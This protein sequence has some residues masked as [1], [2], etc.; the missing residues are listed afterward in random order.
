MYGYPGSFTTHQLSGSRYLTPEQLRSGD[1]VDHANASWPRVFGRL[2]TAIVVTVTVALFLVCAVIAVG[3][4]G[5]DATSTSA[6]QAIV[7]NGVARC[8]VWR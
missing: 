7:C 1:P 2:G 8:P 3:M 4:S 5:S 6:R